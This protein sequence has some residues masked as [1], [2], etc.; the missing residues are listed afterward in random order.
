MAPKT[1]RPY[2][3]HHHSVAIPVVPSASLVLLLVD[4]LSSLKKKIIRTER[5]TRHNTAVA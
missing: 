5:P 3:P 4:S 2:H 1:N